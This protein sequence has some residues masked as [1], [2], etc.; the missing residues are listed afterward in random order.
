MEG[1]PGWKTSSMPGP[2][3][4]QHER[5]SRYITFTHPV[6]LTRWIWK[7]EYDGQRIFGDF[8]DLRLPDICLTGEGKER[9]TSPRK[10]VPNGDR[11]RARCLPCAWRLT[12]T[13]SDLRKTRSSRSIVRAVTRLVCPYWCPEFV[14]FCR[15]GV[16]VVSND[17]P[18]FWGSSVSP[19][20]SIQHTLL[21][22][23]PPL[24]VISYSHLFHVILHLS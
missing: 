16:N 14:S 2:L 22:I 12:D 23:H 10:L 3:P 17:S 20:W 4:R 21:F 19:T 24:H 5:A 6:I 13:A 15:Q 7:D 8:V 18:E 9:K 1:L 11:T